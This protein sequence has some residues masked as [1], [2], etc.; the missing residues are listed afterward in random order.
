MRPPRFALIRFEVA[1]MEQVKPKLKNDTLYLPSAEGIYFV[2][3]HGTL[4][5]DGK[6]IYQWVDKLAPFLT[7]AHTLDEITAN[8]SEDRKRMVVGLISGLAEKGFIKDVSDDRPHGLDED[9]LAAYE[10]EIAFID[11]YRD[12]AAHR[13]Q[14]FRDSKVLLIGSGQTAVALVQACLHAGAREVRVAVTTES[15][16]DRSRIA[17]YVEHARTRDRRQSLVELPD[18]DGSRDAL[19]SAV[20][21]FDVVIH[22]SDKPMLDRAR[23]LNQICVE[24]GT[25]VIQAVVHGGHAWIGPLVTSA[26]RDGA[27]W[28]C[29][30]LRVLGRS[31]A[32]DAR[33]EDR[34]DAVPSEFLAGPT[35]AIVANQLS[36]EVF[37]HITGAGPVETTDALVRLDLETLQS[38][39]HPVTPHPLCAAHGEP[40]PPTEQEFLNAV[41]ELAA[42][43][44]ISREAFSNAAA[45]CFDAATGLLGDL[46]EGDFGQLP[47][48]VSRAEYANAMLLPDFAPEQSAAVEVAT[49]FT[50]ARE[51]A[52]RRACERYAASV[53]DR[54]KL[55]VSGDGEPRTWGL[56]LTTG[57]ARSLS[58]ADVFPALSG[59][60]SAEA[61]SVGL[62][63]GFSW[64]EAVS[65][66]LLA[67]IN[68]I[69]AAE[70]RTAESAFPGIEV[71]ALPQTDLAQR[72]SKMLEILDVEVSVHDITGSLGV[73]TFAACA[74]ADTVGC[75][76]GLDVSQVVEA[77][78][79][80]ALRYHQA[81]TQKWPAYAVGATDHLPQLPSELR[82]A[83]GD[84]PAQPAPGE[85]PEIQALLLRRL[86]EAGHRPVAVPLDHDPVLNRVLPY[87]VKV[88]LEEEN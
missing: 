29:A 85:W 79:E 64:S 74:G 36:F 82:G 60:P 83:P 71:T 43:P 61:D 4:T 22:V 62:A 42:G 56:D 50:E 73:P 39:V 27:C 25:V 1:G 11:Y 53:V 20:E 75:A 28:E 58:A 86:R 8:L 38:S 47:L 19:E 16:T 49:D 10:S 23:L 77:V 45:A 63:S 6:H 34:A 7:G 76:S 70:A 81:R 87:I 2:S 80:Q 55:P 66:G 67:L 78:L 35:A 68:R 21:P 57:G 32:I 84:A 5:L 3:N 88:V 69:T 15:A 59:K 17:T 72:Y 65:R 33:F 52:T 14:T 26:D 9:E 40:T 41:R 44:E 48:K 24:R 46:D 37:K 12:S 13:F 18:L 30:W 51:R 31:A 54:R